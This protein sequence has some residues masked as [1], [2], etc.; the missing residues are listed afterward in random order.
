MW[1]N[2]TPTHE[3]LLNLLHKSPPPPI[4]SLL[5]GTGVLELAVKQKQHFRVRAGKRQVPVAQTPMCRIEQ[6]VLRWSMLRFANAYFHLYQTCVLLRSTGDVCLHFPC[7]RVPLDMGF[8]Y[9]YS[10]LLS[11][12][13]VLFPK[14]CCSL[15]WAS[16]KTI[17]IKAF[18]AT[19][20]LHWYQ[21]NAAGSRG[22]QWVQRIRPREA[23]LEGTWL[24]DLGYDANFNVCP[25]SSHESWSMQMIPK[26][27]KETAIS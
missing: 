11:S 4:D 8:S 24:L 12:R 23:S 16:V 9:A 15:S 13:H 26:H 25:E 17:K 19:A 27:T 21:R 22:K 20:Q 5:R 14:C 2:T 7:L 6:T 18:G 3:N 1:E 10:G